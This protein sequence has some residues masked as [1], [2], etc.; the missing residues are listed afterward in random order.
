MRSEGALALGPAT[1]A[2]AADEVAALR[3]ELDRQP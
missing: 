2:E 3:A 1:A